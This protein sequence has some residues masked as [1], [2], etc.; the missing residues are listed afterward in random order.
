MPSHRR[1]FALTLALVCTLPTLS[2]AAERPVRVIVPY[3]TGGDLD[4]LARIFSEKMGAELKENWIVEN[5]AGGNGRIGTSRMLQAKPDGSTLLFSS[6]IHYLAP[7]VTK[8]TPYDPIADF[9]P[10]GPVVRTPMVLVASPALVKADRLGE[11]IADMKTAPGKYTFAHP[12][13]GASG[14]IASE[15]FMD[16]AK[17]RGTIVP[18]NGTGK[19]ILDVMGGSVSF[20][21]MTPL[22]ASHHLD[23]GKLKPIATTSQ[24]R[25]SGPL[26][27]IPTTAEA[28]LPSVATKNVYGFWAAKGLPAAELTRLSDALRKVTEMPDIKQ[29]LETLGM[30][31]T[32]E[33]P[34]TFAQNIEEELKQTRAVLTRAGVQ[35]E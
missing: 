13:R 9:V 14:H 26:K 1:L 11:V 33:S 10:V 15:I 23:S 25:L 21:F 31:P 35:P 8:G 20:V 27:H 16:A 7:L 28:G 6:S 24:T 17:V 22:L 29:R 19:A 12:G 18:Y 5:I 4:T 34:A 2:H 32:W 3:A 30:Q